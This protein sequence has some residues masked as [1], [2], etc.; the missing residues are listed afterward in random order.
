MVME[1]LISWCCV[2]QY[3]PCVGTPGYFDFDVLKSFS[4]RGL[5]Q[6][7][8]DREMEKQ[9]IKQHREVDGTASGKFGRA[10]E[11]EDQP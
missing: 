6:M 1:E 11:A 8:Q 7:E 2:F 9:K 4:S 3:Q 5:A 10:S